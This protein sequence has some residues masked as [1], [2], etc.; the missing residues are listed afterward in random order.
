MQGEQKY[1]YKEY[2]LRRITPPPP[3]RVG[4]YHMLLFIQATQFL[5]SRAVAPAALG[6]EIMH[7][8]V[9]RPIITLVVTDTRSTAVQVSK[10]K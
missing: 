6:E 8:V 2:T 4:K 5:S 3:G 7:K 9:N 10:S 1:T